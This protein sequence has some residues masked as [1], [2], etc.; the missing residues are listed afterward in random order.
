MTRPRVF[1][2]CVAVVIAG[3]ATAEA[4]PLET[5]VVDPFVFAGPDATMAFAQTRAAGASSVRLVLDWASVA[6]HRPSLDSTDDASRAYRWGSFDRQVQ[7]AI[8]SG[9]RPIVCV[10]HTPVWARA[11]GRGGPAST[12]PRPDELARFGR[13]AAQRY[14]GTVFNWEVWNEPNARSSL[15]PQFVRGRP[16]TPAHYR[17]MVNAFAK[18]VRAVDRRNVIVAG[19]LAPFGHRSKEIAV[20]PPMRF[21]RDL[22]CISGTG[23]NRSNCA[24]TSFDVWSHHPYTQ[25]GPTHGASAPDDVSLGDLPRM[26][27][28]LNT[29]ARLGRI[30]STMPVRFWVTEFS[31]DSQP[32]D[33]RGVP[34]ALHARWVAEALYRMWRSGVTL[35]TW[36]RIRD[37][38]LRASP[39][40]SGLFFDASR[41]SGRPKPALRAFRFPFVALREAGAVRVW[42]RVPPGRAGPVVVE[43]RTAVGW[44]R[45]V[46]LQPDGDGIFE[47]LIR[48][49]GSTVRGR[50]ADGTDATLPF[51][52]NRPPDVPATPFGCGGKIA[53]ARR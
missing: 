9:L 18:A 26:R 7:E 22:L 2:V 45:L 32:G 50:L 14:A 51:S 47:R 20:V 31:W 25:G 23:T 3:T 1:A 38:P 29:A 19:G 35:V 36:W 16:A 17:S 30:R 53:C 48:A 28:L 5:A 41:A 4:R 11:T 10:T 24:R 52:L 15:R 46:V 43:T 34:L 49:K 37:D 27:R 12:W 44:R 39:Y 21:M 8:A 40:Q 13:A 42:G 6:P 33:P